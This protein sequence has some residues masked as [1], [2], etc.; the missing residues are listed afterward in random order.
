MMTRGTL[1]KSQPSPDQTQPTAGPDQHRAGHRLQSPD[2]ENYIQY[3]KMIKY[4]IMCYFPDH[5]PH[6]LFT[7][8][9][10][11]HS[12]PIIIVTAGILSIW[13]VSLR[14]G[15]AV[16]QLRRADCGVVSREEGDLVNCLVR[17]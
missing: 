14:G 4:Y 5:V 13:V 17:E 3:V 11:S 8:N 6:S 7:I 12:W 16:L 9:I 15:T 10:V 1:R 2:S